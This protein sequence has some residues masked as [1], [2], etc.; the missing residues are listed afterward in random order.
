[1]KILDLKETSVGV[2]IYISIL[3]QDHQ[4]LEI[5]EDDPRWPRFKNMA[6]QLVKQYLPQYKNFP[7]LFVRLEEDNYG[8]REMGGWRYR[9][10]FY[11]KKL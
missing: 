5:F 8:Y 10:E 3:D 2:M 7:L 11:F 6:R 9:C 1:M 4:S